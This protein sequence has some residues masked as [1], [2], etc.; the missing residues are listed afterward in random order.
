MAVVLQIY[1]T[2]TKIWPAVGTSAVAVFEG[3]RWWLVEKWAVNRR[4]L[5]PAEGWRWGGL[6]RLARAW[7]LDLHVAES[8]H[9]AA[10]MLVVCW[11]CWMGFY[12]QFLCFSF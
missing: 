1:T 7:R 2:T 3:E 12:L 4:P 5:I 9:V 11:A 10:P 8:A 6:G